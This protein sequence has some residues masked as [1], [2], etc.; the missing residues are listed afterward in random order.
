MAETLL[1][2]LGARMLG[3]SLAWGT[4]AGGLSLLAGIGLALVLGRT[5][6]LRVTFPG[7]RV[8]LVEQQFLPGVVRGTVAVGERQLLLSGALWVLGA[9]LAPIAL[10]WLIDVLVRLARSRRSAVSPAGS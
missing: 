5:R 8:A 6:A 4:V 3:S 10:L 1:R 7:A 9:L 2:L